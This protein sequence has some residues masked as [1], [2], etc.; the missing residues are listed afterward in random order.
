M[1][2]PAFPRTRTVLFPAVAAVLCVTAG[3][4]FDRESVRDLGFELLT[5][6]VVI[7]TL[8]HERFGPHRGRTQKS[9]ENAESHAP[10]SDLKGGAHGSDNPTAP[11]GRDGVRDALDPAGASLLQK[12]HPVT[13]NQ[14]NPFETPGP[15]N[16]P[17]AGDPTPPP[18]QP[19]VNPGQTPPPPPADPTPPAPPS[20]P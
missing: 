18:K 9:P 19:P 11:E 13:F 17:P 5:A 1:R 15:M 6:A 12:E 10:G 4:V 20:A 16:T 3:C 7:A 14:T 8:L 2:P